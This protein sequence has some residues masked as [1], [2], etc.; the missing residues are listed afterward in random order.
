[1]LK[2]PPKQTSTEYYGVGQSGYTAGRVEGDLALE[3]QLEDRNARYPRGTDERSIETT[4][5]ERFTG[6][7]GPHWAPD[8]APA[9]RR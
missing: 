6:R 4:D 2:E 7:G 5:D 8:E 3:L 9:A 1:M